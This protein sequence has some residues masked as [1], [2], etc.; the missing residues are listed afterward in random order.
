MECAALV[1]HCVRAADHDTTLVSD[2]HIDDESIGRA[3]RINALRDFEPQ[4]AMKIGTGDSIAS[5]RG[6]F[7]AL[8]EGPRRRSGG[9]ERPRPLHRS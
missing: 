3:V 6:R 8:A 1:I 9:G 2:D 4:A 7:R 5:D